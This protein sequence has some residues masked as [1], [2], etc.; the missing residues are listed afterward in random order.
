MIRIVADDKMPFLK[1]A[2]E[3]FAEVKYLPGR[4]ISN[5][6]IKN[7][8][9]LLI[10]TR[11]KCT[12]KL[13]GNTPVKFIGT[14]T[15]GFDHIDAQYCEK[16]NIDWTNAPGCNSSSVQQ[17][18]AAALLKLARDHRFK[19]KGKTIGIVGV[20]NVGKKV[21]KFARFL[22]M[23]VLLNDPPRAR[24]EG[25]TN[26]VTLEDVLRESDII[27]LHV[28]LHHVGEDKTYHL[29]DENCFKM[30]R[31]PVWFINSSRGEV[32]E[33]AA[34]KKNLESGK[35]RG[36]VLDVWENEPDIDFSLVPKAYIATPHI[37]GYSIDGKAKGT[38]MVVNSLS[39][40]FDLPLRDWYPQDVPI[41]EIP[42]IFIDCKGKSNQR[43]VSQVVSHT[44]SIEDDDT[45]FRYNP[46]DFEN[47]RGDYPLRREFHAFTVNLK[48]AKNDIHMILE[49]LGFIVKEPGREV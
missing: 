39:R 14:A 29:F 21:E 5:T 8:D 24:E 10:R 1:G 43:I 15:I 44:Y 27:T 20:G 25:D 36:A 33:T 48:N 32:V 22:G 9:A 26:F 42:D 16:N 2:L 18:I 35:L 4:I 40:F 49:E 17:Y 47:L 41:P 3:P 46:S 6:L 13:L 23:K 11:T 38:A 12:E 31:K 45:N 28:P 30:I 37:A 34:L 19:L 7:A